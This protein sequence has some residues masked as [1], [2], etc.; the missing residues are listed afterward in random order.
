VRRGTV[1]REL[2]ESV[3]E[4]ARG[5]R[6]YFAFMTISG[7]LAAVAFLT[8][9]I[10]LLL[11]AMIVAPAYPSLAAVSFGLAAGYPRHA[12]R[13]FAQFLAGI[14][15]AV[16]AAIATTWFCDTA[17]IIDV[18]LVE[19]PLLEER[20]RPGWYSLIAAAAAGTAGTIAVIR[21]K[22]DTLIGVVASIALVPAA[23]AGGVATYAGHA[24]R[25][26]GGFVLLFVNFSVIVACGLIV[27][28]VVRP[29]RATRHDPDSESLTIRDH[30]ERRAW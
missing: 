18:G 14:L 11:G 13:A 19:R 24:A 28:L 7:V 10:P 22:R 15:A 20:V 21:R 30:D 26:I 1:D 23:T 12:G 5:D 17:G 16:A 8:D 4:D 29:G 25:G 3:F 6:A 9:S 27:L 2:V